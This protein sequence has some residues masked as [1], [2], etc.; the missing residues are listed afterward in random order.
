MPEN[1]RTTFEISTLRESA[2]ITYIGNQEAHTSYLCPGGAT[3]IPGT[4]GA[5]VS[6]GFLV[7]F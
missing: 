3:N 4:K 1:L 7:M 5:S 6:S 2:D